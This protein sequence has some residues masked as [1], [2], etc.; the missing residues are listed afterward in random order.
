[1]YFHNFETFGTALKE[2]KT[3]QITVA[4]KD[5]SLENLESTKISI[6]QFR[7]VYEEI[8]VLINARAPISIWGGGIIEMVPYEAIASIS[9]SFAR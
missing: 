2:S 1:M 6:D 8:E 9:F 5:D 3:F 7:A 4:M